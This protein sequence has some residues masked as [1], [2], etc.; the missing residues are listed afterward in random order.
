MNGRGQDYQDFM[1]EQRIDQLMQELDDLGMIC[2]CGGVFDKSRIQGEI[3][4]DCPSC[5]ETYTVKK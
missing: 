2:K 4:Y 5:G 1:E 3:Q